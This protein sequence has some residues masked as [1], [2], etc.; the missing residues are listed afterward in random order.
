MSPSQVDQKT[1]RHC[2][3]TLLTEAEAQQRTAEAMSWAVQNFYTPSLDWKAGPG[4]R[5][6]GEAAH[7]Q[8][9]EKSRAFFFFFKVFFC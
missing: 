6:G 3:A 9:A 4:R 5:P 2:G 8:N 7:F 1:F